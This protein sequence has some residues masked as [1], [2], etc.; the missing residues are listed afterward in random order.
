M[1]IVKNI[2]KNELYLLGIL[3][4]QEILRLLMKAGKYLSIDLKLAIIMIIT[5]AILSVIQQIIKE[6]Y[7]QNHDSRKKIK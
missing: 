1:K 6:T 7:I 5:V 4:F 3:V 2:I